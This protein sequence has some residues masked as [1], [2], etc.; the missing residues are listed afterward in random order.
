[1]SSAVLGMQVALS[2][3]PL[4]NGLEPLGLFMSFWQLYKMDLRLDRDQAG[5]STTA[6]G[7]ADRG[8]AEGE[9]G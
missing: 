9:G 4:A 3:L 7:R 1:M 5:N 8:K 6:V 2:V